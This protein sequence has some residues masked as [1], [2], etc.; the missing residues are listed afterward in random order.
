MDVVKQRGENTNTHSLCMQTRGP[1][2]A[3]T[4]SSVMSSRCA[5][6]AGEGWGG[7]GGWGGWADSSCA[8]AWRDAV[9]GDAVSTDGVAGRALGAGLGGSERDPPTSGIT[10]GQAGAGRER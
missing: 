8:Q 4:V 6:R 7:W 3:L 9:R 2:L 5:P 10:S 1:S